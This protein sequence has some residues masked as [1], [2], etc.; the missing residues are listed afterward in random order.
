MGSRRGWPVTHTPVVSKVTIPALLVGGNPARRGA[1]VGQ[2]LVGR[3]GKYGTDAPASQRLRSSSPFGLRGV[4]QFPQTAIPSTMYWPRA[5]SVVSPA[6][7][8]ASW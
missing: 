6:A 3:A 7:F 8:L 5:T 1:T 4:W 2:S